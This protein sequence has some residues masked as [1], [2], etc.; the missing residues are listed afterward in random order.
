MIFD[1]V[2]RALRGQPHPRGL[3]DT[4]HG[5]NRRGRLGLALYVSGCVFLIASPVWFALN[6]PV[7]LRIEG[8]EPISIAGFGTGATVR[9]AFQ[10]PVDALSGISVRISSDQSSTLTLFCRL[11]QVSDRS[12]GAE[13]HPDAYTEIYRW[14][15][16]LNVPAGEAWH[17]FEFPLVDASTGRWYA[18]E[19]RLFEASPMRMPAA[20]ATRPA[21]AIAAS[22]DNPA[23][24]GKLWVDGVRQ[25]GSLFIR[26]HK[27]SEEARTYLLVVYPWTLGALIYL[28]FFAG[29]GE[30]A[31]SQAPPRS[32]EQA[33]PV[34]SLVLH[35]AWI[36][37]VVF[38]TVAAFVPRAMEAT[39]RM[40]RTSRAAGVYEW[41]PGEPNEFGDARFRWMKR[42]AALH[43]PVRG[44]VLQVPLFID[45]PAI[46]TSPVTVRVTVAGVDTPPIVLQRRGWQTATYNLPEMFGESDWKSLTAITLSFNF[47][48]LADDESL[49]RV[50]L[51]DVHW[52]GPGPQ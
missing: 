1:R 31:A 9:H 10:M 16:R 12:E 26:A 30:P 41:M 32:N 2:V 17:R 43:E 49:P 39:R 4:P 36:P 7:V 46:E 50:G 25:P 18:F 34:R 3:A 44:R 6:R 5:S 47:T 8:A 23:R 52:S 13:D 20:A 14:T 11:L 33:F 21:V 35:R 45:R 24:G 37:A 19:I 51:G 29:K 15:E 27:R 40:A 48:G 22:R 28:V 38:V 42:R